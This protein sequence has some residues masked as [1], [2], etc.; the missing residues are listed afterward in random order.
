M[1]ITPWKPCT[2]TLVSRSR[3]QNRGTRTGTVEPQEPRLQYRN[4]D[5]T[6]KSGPYQHYQKP[7][8]EIKMWTI[9]CFSFILINL[10]TYH[11]ILD[12]VFT[13][14]ESWY[15]VYFIIFQCTGQAIFWMSSKIWRLCESR[16]CN[17]RR[18]SWGRIQR[19]RYGWAMI[20]TRGGQRPLPTQSN[21]N[22][23]LYTKS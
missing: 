21:N 12:R 19:W 18:L 20:K 22:L 23:L 4:R 9:Q 8:N 14:T 10:F 1:Q 11:S 17:S 7:G 6:E 2:E 13:V 5:W 15:M 16:K 3:N